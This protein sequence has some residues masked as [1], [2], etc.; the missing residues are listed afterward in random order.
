MIDSEQLS[1]RQAVTWLGDSITVRCAHRLLAC[2][3][4]DD[5]AAQADETG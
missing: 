3:R 4:L 2:A 1:L 5:P